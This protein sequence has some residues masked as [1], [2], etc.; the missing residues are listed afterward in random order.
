MSVRAASQRLREPL[1]QRILRAAPRGV[2]VRIVA[3]RAT[4]ENG[5]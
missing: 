4:K 2:D 1:P 5:S 3:G